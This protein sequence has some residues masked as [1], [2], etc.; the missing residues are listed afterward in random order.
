MLIGHRR[1]EERE[2]T[3]DIEE[4]FERKGNFYY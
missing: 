4:R 1:A 3:G 2:R